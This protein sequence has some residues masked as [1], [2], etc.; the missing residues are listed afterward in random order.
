LLFSIELLFYS[1]LPNVSFDEAEVGAGM[2][3]F[4]N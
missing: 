4:K 2:K 1:S 3:L